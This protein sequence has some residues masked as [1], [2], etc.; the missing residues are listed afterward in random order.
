MEAAEAMALAK[1]M[2]EYR[3]DIVTF[4]KALEIRD[5]KQ[6]SEWTSDQYKF[7]IQF[8]RLRMLQ[9]HVRTLQLTNGSNG[10]KK[11]KKD[12]QPSRLRLPG[13][14][15]LLADRKAM[16][17]QCKKYSD[18]GR[19]VAPEGCDA[20]GSGVDGNNNGCRFS[21]ADKSGAGGRF[22][23][24]NESSVDGNDNGCRF[25]SADE[26]TANGNDNGGRFSS[27][28]ESGAG[29]RFSAADESSDDGNIGCRFSSADGSSAGG[30]FSSADESSVDGN[31]GC[32]FS[33]AH[34]SSYGK[35]SDDLSL[36]SDVAN[37]SLL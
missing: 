32:R 8:K 13:F 7:M 1:R 12:K 10:G 11:K 16:W 26:S 23:S 3:N 24:A 19:P 18:P 5:M 20:D 6:E 34:E 4:E 2:T 27:A 29:G 36:L 30:R 9:D 28:D 15:S 17:V 31:N 25:S 35:Q 21:S 14:P 22:S 37:I 33:S